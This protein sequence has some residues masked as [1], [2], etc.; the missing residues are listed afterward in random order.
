MVTELPV[1]SR[2]LLALVL[3]F[4]RPNQGDLCPHPFKVERCTCPFL[5]TMTFGSPNPWEGCLGWSSFS[6]KEVFC[7]GACYN[8]ALLGAQRV[9]WRGYRSGTNL[10]FKP[11][12]EITSW[13]KIYLSPPESSSWAPFFCSF[14]WPGWEWMDHIT[15]YTSN[16]AS[17][18]KAVCPA[19]VKL[20]SWGGVL[21][22]Y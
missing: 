14:P 8:C 9:K 1:L 4:G 16:N 3:K 19:F 20:G 13:L 22:M 21:K 5:A 10:L 11:F 17:G 12:K 18:R 2:L 7:V 6:S 15:F